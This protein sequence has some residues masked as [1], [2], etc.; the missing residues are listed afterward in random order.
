M[1]LREDP[2]SV[3]EPVCAYDDAGRVRNGKNRSDGILD[4]L[5]RGGDVRVLCGAREEEV[6]GVAPIENNRSLVIPGTLHIACTS[7][8]LFIR[9]RPGIRNCVATRCKR[10]VLI[11]RFSISRV[12]VHRPWKIGSL[13]C[14]DIQCLVSKN[15]LDVYIWLEW[16]IYFLFSLYNTAF[17]VVICLV[18]NGYHFP[19]NSRF[20]GESRGGRDEYDVRFHFSRERRR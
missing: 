1:T 11:Q 5:G 13:G 2:S 17:Y 14:M 10:A 8:A 20:D 15:Y 16:T 7:C 3:E 12:W 4:W 18:H 19:R 9:D 6:P